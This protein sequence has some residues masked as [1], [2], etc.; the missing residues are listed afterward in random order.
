MFKEWLMNYY[1]SCLIGTSLIAVVILVVRILFAGKLSRRFAYGLWITIPAFMLLVSFVSIPMPH[2]IRIPQRIIEKPEGE[3]SIQVISLEERTELEQDINILNNNETET[4]S[5]TADVN[6]DGQFDEKDEIS[7]IKV[8]KEIDWIVLAGTIYF[9]LVLGIVAGVYSTNIKFEHRCRYNR[10]YLCETPNSKLPVYQM[11]NIASPFLLFASVYVPEKMTETELKFAMLHEEEHFKHADF[12][13]VIIRYLILAIFFYNPIIWLAFK[14]S[15]YDCEL[16]CDE[17]VI[18]KIESSERITYGNCLLDVIK[19]QKKVS[20]RVLLSTNMKAGKKLIRARIENIVSTQKK[21][22]PIM[23][24]TIF[25]MFFVAGCALMKQDDNLTNAKQDGE[26]VK[27]SYDGDVSS[28]NTERET[29]NEESSATNEGENVNKQ[30]EGVQDALIQYEEKFFLSVDVMRKIKDEK[31]S[32]ETIVDNEQLEILIGK[33]YL[34]Y[35]TSVGGCDDRIIDYIIHAPHN[36]I[37][38]RIGDTIRVMQVIE[39]DEYYFDFLVTS[40]NDMG[41]ANIDYSDE[42]KGD[43]QLPVV[44]EFMENDDAAKDYGFENGENRLQNRVI[45]EY[46]RAKSSSELAPYGNVGY[47]PMNLT[48]PTCDC[49]W[50]E[51]VKGY[52]I[53]ETIHFMQMYMGEGVERITFDKLCIVNGYAQNED[54][55]KN[56]SRVKSM[57]MY[58]FDEYI[59][60][61]HLEDTI[62]PQYIDLSDVILSIGNGREARFKFEIC[63]VYEGDKY[64]DTCLTGIEFSYVTN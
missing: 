28:V 19:R 11:E 45:K 46:S 21:S 40:I 6:D 35:N 7:G 30:K 64:E 44:G 4:D 43:L 36:F 50:S 24:T 55:W 58:Y 9:I 39:E 47:S 48:V 22:L 56:N 34:A 60:M 14:Y 37:G 59:G 20:E 25:L 27:I 57:K 8:K 63:E 5:K 38:K 33:D 23:L 18:S 53:G 54:K 32:Y 31:E 61:I 17:A 15:G 2:F 1:I 29:E 16:A 49:I 26:Y 10:K 41:K 62:K 51:G 42:W 13:W 12:L 3:I 52:G